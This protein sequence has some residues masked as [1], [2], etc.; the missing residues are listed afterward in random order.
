MMY[1]MYKSFVVLMVYIISIYQSMKFLYDSLHIYGGSL[2]VFILHV[3]VLYE[4]L[5]MVIQGIQVYYTLNESLKKV[6][7][8][9]IVTHLN[10]IL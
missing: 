7:L 6:Y 10:R 4:C 8:L 5:I 3:V 1:N 2:I 9:C